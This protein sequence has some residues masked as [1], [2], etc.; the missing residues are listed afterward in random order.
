MGRLRNLGG[1][2]SI[3][4]ETETAGGSTGGFKGASRVSWSGEGGQE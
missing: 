3:F 1:T 2:S 4:G